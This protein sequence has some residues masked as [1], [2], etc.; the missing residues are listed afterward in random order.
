MCPKWNFYKL[1]L[2][3][4]ILLSDAVRR[5]FILSLFFFPSSNQALLL[6]CSYF[7]NSYSYSMKTVSLLGSADRAQPGL[8]GY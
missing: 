5:E 6:L 3:L 1:L 4:Q 7:S 8:R 2:L